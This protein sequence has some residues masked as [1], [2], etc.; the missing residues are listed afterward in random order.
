MYFFPF[1]IFSAFF[2]QIAANLSYLN[3]MCAKFQTNLRIFFSWKK[4]PAT[5]KEFEFFSQKYPRFFNLKLDFFQVRIFSAFF[6]PNRGKFIL[7]KLD[8]W[9]VSDKLENLFFAEKSA[10]YPYGIWFFF[11][12]ISTWSW[13][14]FRFKTFFTYFPNSGT[15]ILPK[16]HICRFEK[17]SE[18]ILRAGGRQVAHHDYP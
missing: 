6:F 14:I 9:K 8:V 4:V 18:N 3:Y 7:P 13:N 15:F 5:H 17:K 11:S 2:F 12:K 16:L 1:R 10:D